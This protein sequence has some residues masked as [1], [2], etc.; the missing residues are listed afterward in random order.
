MM[1]TSHVILFINMQ[2]MNVT[3]IDLTVLIENFSVIQVNYYVTVLYCT[4]NEHKSYIIIIKSINST[5]AVKST[6]VTHI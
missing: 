6:R 1:C 2:L 3:Y 4:L 5:F